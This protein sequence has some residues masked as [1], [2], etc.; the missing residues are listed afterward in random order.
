[1]GPGRQTLPDLTVSGDDV[2]ISGRISQPA[3]PGLRLGDSALDSARRWP[4]VV[5]YVDYNELS[6]M[7]GYPLEPA[8]VLLNPGTEGGYLRNW[9][10]H[11]A[12][13]GPERH[14]G[15][16]VQWFSLAIALL[17]IYLVVNTRRYRAEDVPST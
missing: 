4:H 8:V 13:F 9:H 2:V 15:Y 16:A 3:N 10:P 7:L 5:Q 11:F 1:L 17:V 6:A 12:G 14:R